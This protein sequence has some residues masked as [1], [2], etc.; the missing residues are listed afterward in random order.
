MQL[1]QG[2]EPCLLGV[3]A[4]DTDVDDLEI[5]LGGRI[6][7]GRCAPQ[8]LALLAK[9][10]SLRLAVLAGQ[11]LLLVVTDEEDAVEV[12]LE[13]GE[14]AGGDG[15]GQS[16]A[17]QMPGVQGKRPRSGE[18]KG[19]TELER[20]MSE[21]GADACKLRGDPSELTDIQ[22]QWSCTWHTGRDA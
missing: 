19:D 4:C 12:R 5:A 15:R 17:Q 18:L 21:L 13:C 3:V 7:N 8:R 22:V 2:V 1:V 10:G 9:G 16:L 6:A 14:Q 20:D 11:D